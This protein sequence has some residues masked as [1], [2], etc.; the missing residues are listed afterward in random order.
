MYTLIAKNDDRFIASVRERIVQKTKGTNMIRILVPNEKNGVYMKDC[1]A[2]MFYKL[3]ISDEWHPKELIPSEELYQNN[4][5]EYLFPTDTW[6]TAEYGDVV[7][8]LRFYNVSLS[9]GVNVDQYLRRITDGIIHI[10]CSKDWASGIADDLLSPID[11]R[12]IQLMMVQNRQD[13][14]IAESQLL[15]AS[16]LLV[17]DGKLYLVDNVGNKKGDPAD[18]VVP[19][20]SDVNDFANDGLIEIDNSAPEDESHEDGCDCG[21]NHDFVELDETIDINTPET[22]NDN[23]FLEV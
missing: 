17:E 14:M 13:E 19:R 1:Q 10:S 21:C 12:I 22:D 11:Q 5:V 16:S 15:S 7:I 4:Y 3:P 2:I 20:V 8:E 6:L 9:D 23:G 18:I